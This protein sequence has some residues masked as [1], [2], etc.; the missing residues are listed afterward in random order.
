MLATA[1]FAVIGDPGSGGSGEAA[2][3]RMVK[4]WSPQFVV[5]TG[6]N[7]YASAG[8]ANYDRTLGPFYGSFIGGY[9]GAYGTG[10]ADNRFFSAMGNHDW[11][12]S[13][14]AAYT[15]FLKLPGNERYYD[16]VKGPVHFFFLSTDPREPA[17]T[18]ATST[19]ANWLRAKMAASTSA[20]N[21]VV[22]HHPPYTSGNKHPVATKLR[23][24][25]KAWGA[26]L[27]IDGHEHVYE[28]IERPNGLTYVTNGVSGA[29]RSGFLSAPTTGSAKRYQANFG[30]MKMYASE[31]ELRWSL[32][33]I[34]GQTIDTRVLRQAAARTAVFSAQRIAPPLPVAKS[35]IFR[36]VLNTSETTPAELFG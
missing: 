28:R 21:V 27:V 6:D 19:Q 16:V 33:N 4:N 35:E 11:E 32:I 20:W 8:N 15:R 5:S 17:G 23:W 34:A 9:K 1:S 3:A 36:D 14:G 22:M 30:A 31:T 29:G 26:D 10:P 24:D 13:N 18:S 12:T 2:V 7:T 25:F